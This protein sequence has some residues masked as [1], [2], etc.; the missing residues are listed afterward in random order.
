MPDN[1]LKEL[2]N[3]IYSSIFG[4]AKLKRNFIKFWYCQTFLMFL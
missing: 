4:F 1:F 2:Y 3:Y